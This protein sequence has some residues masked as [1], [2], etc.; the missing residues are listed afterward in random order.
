MKI[1]NLFAE[2][3]VSTVV[4]KKNPEGELDSDRDPSCRITGR[5][6]FFVVTKQNY[7]WY[8]HPEE[9]WASWG[10]SFSQKIESANPAQLN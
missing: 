7:Y 8:R 2:I 3:S 10:G 1:L 5:E 6:P 4:N 9:R